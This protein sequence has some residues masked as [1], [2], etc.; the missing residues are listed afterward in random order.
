M[1]R[2]IEDELQEPFHN[3]SFGY[4]KVDA[5]HVDRVVPAEVGQFTRSHVHV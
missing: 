5:I 2:I 1:G 4:L 3:V